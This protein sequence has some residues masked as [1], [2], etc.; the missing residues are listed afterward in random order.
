MPM[1]LLTIIFLQAILT[2]PSIYWHAKGSLDARDILTIPHRGSD[3]ITLGT[4]IKQSVDKEKT[5][6]TAASEKELQ[7]FAEIQTSRGAKMFEFLNASNPARALTYTGYKY[8]VASSW[9]LEGYINFKDRITGKRIVWKVDEEKIQAL[10][11]NFNVLFYNGNY[12][13]FY[14]PTPPSG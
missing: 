13:M 4:W 2:M 14:L 12:S 10:Y 9:L 8:I 5:L 7:F 11:N 6:L 1:F 3:L